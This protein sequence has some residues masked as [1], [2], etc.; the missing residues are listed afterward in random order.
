MNYVIIYYAVAANSR[1]ASGNWNTNAADNCI[2]TSDCNMQGNKVAG[3]GTGSITFVNAR[4]YNYYQLAVHG[5]CTF[6][7]R[8][9]NGCFG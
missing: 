2:I 9:A 5:G 1:P 3:Y 6:V 8:S 7:C 4:I